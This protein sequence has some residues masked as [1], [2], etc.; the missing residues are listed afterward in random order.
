MWLYQLARRLLPEW[1]QDTS[2]DR[3]HPHRRRFTA[4]YRRKRAIVKNLWI[5]SG[6]VMIVEATPAFIFAVALGTTFMA[7]VILDETR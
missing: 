6:L 4:S 3:D 7:F 1:T 2:P 5:G